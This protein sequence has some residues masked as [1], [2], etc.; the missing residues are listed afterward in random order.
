MLL[1][2]LFY[3]VILEIF[4]VIWG[5]VGGIMLII[6]VKFLRLKFK[7]IFSVKYILG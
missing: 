2:V 1:C 3:I 7:V 6:D 5:W 4:V